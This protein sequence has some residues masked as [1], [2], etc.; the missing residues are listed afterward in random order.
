VA[1]LLLKWFGTYQPCGRK[2]I[3]SQPVL[4][5]WSNQTNS[6]NQ[7]DQTDQKNQIDQSVQNR[8][9][10][11]MPTLVFSMKCDSKLSLRLECCTPPNPWMD[12]VS[13]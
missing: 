13:R 3:D 11:P 2:G 10:R 5:V 4:F 8:A 9:E 1:V 6:M 7:I 12:S